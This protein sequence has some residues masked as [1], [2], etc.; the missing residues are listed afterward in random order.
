MEAS[1]LWRRP[2]CG[3]ILI[4]GVLIVGCPYYGGVIIMEVSK[5][6]ALHTSL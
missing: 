3:G 4:V 6:H 1:G 5:Y 2:D